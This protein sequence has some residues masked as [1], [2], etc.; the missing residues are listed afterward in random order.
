MLG[1]FIFYGVMVNLTEVVIH[2]HIF[3]YIYICMKYIYINMYIYIRIGRFIFLGVMANLTEEVII[4][5]ASLSLPKSPFRIASTL[6]HTDPEEYNKI[7]RH[8]FFSRSRLDRGHLSEPL[9][10]MGALLEWRA[11]QTEKEKFDWCQSNCIAHARMRSLH[12]V[13]TNL[14]SRLSVSTNRS[15]YGHIFVL[16][17]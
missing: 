16:T 15:R 1:K 17:H 13:A 2:I 14:R 4:M 10:L 5:A 9:M 8:G 3:I 12:S 11:C 7:V 6:I